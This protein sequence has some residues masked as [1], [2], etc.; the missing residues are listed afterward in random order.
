LLTLVLPSYYVAQE[1]LGYSPQVIAQVVGLDAVEQIVSC[2]GVDVEVW[3]SGEPLKELDAQTDKTLRERNLG[4]VAYQGLYAPAYS[5]FISAHYRALTENTVQ[6]WDDGSSKST[7]DIF[8][9]DGSVGPR[10]LSA[11]CE[12]QTEFCCTAEERNA[13]DWS[14]SSCVQGRW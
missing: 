3:G 9:E 11:W 12:N 8:P 4:A 14:V 2:N 1:L 7:M 6:I 5:S 10:N 13:L